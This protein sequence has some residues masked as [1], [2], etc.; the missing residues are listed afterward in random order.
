[1]VPAAS[2]AAPAALVAAALVADS[3]GAVASA[4]VAAMAEAAGIGK[5]CRR[6]NCGVMSG[7]EGSAGA[8]IF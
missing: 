7:Y 6:A 1:V 3:A 4:A 5:V 2:V 8:D